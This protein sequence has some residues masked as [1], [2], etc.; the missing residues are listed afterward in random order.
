MGGWFD[1]LC[2]GFGLNKER[3]SFLVRALWVIFVS[4]HI[5][6]VCGFLAAAGVASPFATA[7]EVADKYKDIAAKQ[8]AAAAKADRI[9]KLLQKQLI[10]SKA[11]EIREVVLQICVAQT[12]G[13]KVRLLE[14]K[15]DLQTEYSELT[16]GFKYPEPPCEQLR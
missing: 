2:E 7:G 6:W 16:V 13:E 4:G 14:K 8:D 12:R 9:E 15:D 3:R 5:A 10:R 1:T 11:T